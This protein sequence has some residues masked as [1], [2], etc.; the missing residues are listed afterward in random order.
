MPNELTED[1]VQEIAEDYLNVMFHMGEFTIDLEETL[2][3]TKV[4]IRMTTSP[5]LLVNM[6]T[7]YRL[8]NGMDPY[9]YRKPL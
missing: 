7:R 9:N 6:L 8:T 5:K 3:R 4:M 2:E 1:Q